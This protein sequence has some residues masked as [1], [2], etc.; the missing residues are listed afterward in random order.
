MSL[1]V[2]TNIFVYALNR[3]SDAHEPAR[4][5][6][7]SLASRTDVVIAELI[8]VE[9]YL[10]IRNPVIFPNPY[11]APEAVEACRAFGRNPNWRI[12]E[13]RPVM[14]GVWDV[15][16]TPDFAR[17]RII[18]ARLALTLR[19]A[20]VTELATRNTADFESFGFERVFDPLNT[21]PVD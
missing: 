10:L 18:D 19:A 12:V 16:R 17:R 9:I 1:S 21:A 7:Q 15:A 8:L 3:N 20:G 11:A 6:L 14:D 5:F 4:S 13:C 2:D